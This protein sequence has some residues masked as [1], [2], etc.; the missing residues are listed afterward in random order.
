MYAFRLRS[1]SISM[2]WE[3]SIDEGG[4]RQSLITM[5]SLLPRSLVVF[6][7]SKVP[8]ED[9]LGRAAIPVM[10]LKELLWE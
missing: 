2:S 3:G 8:I 4:G 5:R 7:W 6:V 1:W 10:V 9:W